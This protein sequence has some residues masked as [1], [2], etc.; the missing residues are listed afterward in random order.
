MQRCISTAFIPT[1]RSFWPGI[2][3]NSGGSSVTVSKMRKRA[4]LV[5]RFMLQMI[6]VPLFSKESKEDESNK[7]NSESHSC[8][9]QML[10]DFDNG[11]EG[12]AIRIAAEVKTV[13]PGWFSFVAY[14]SFEPVRDYFSV[15]QHYSYET[16]ASLILMLSII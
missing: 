2:C 1:V 14:P 6:Q 12:I 9:L 7:V 3:G 13:T 11:V 5:A 16:C 8:S 10:D 4:L 15:F